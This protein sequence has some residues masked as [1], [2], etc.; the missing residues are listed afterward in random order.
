MSKIA[1]RGCNASP[2]ARRARRRRAAQAVLAAVFT[3][4]VTSPLSAAPAH[5]VVIAPTGA[6]AHSWGYCHTDTVTVFTNR[7]EF[8]YRRTWIYSNNQ[9]QS[10]P[11]RTLSI[12]QDTKDVYLTSGWTAVYVEYADWLGNGNWSMVGEFATLSGDS[13]PYWCLAF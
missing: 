9:W 11:W 7:T 8:E 12:L 6:G 10:T 5:A 3:T 1:N 13:G 2:R 4:L